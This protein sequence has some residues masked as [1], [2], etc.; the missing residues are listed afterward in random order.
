MGMGA[1]ASG[2]VESADGAGRASIHHGRF[3][4]RLDL[5]R[6]EFDDQVVEKLIETH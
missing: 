2:C 5:S 3:E 6:P 1:M 4:A